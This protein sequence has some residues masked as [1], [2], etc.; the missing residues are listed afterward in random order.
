M[1]LH[2]GTPPRPTQSYLPTR[3]SEEGHT[4]R[5]GDGASKNMFYSSEALAL[6]PSV[7]LQAE[8][9]VHRLEA[10]WDLDLKLCGWS[11]LALANRNI[12]AATHV[13]LHFLMATF[14]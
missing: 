5:Q 1:A 9:F 3:S 8:L 2:K 14:K 11:T 7:E 12:N 4:Q 10:S 6:N 13:I